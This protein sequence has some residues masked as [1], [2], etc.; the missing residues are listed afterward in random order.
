MNLSGGGCS[1]EQSHSLKPFPLSWLQIDKKFQNFFALINKKDPFSMENL[2]HY[3]LYRSIRDRKFNVTDKI[4]ELISLR[5]TLG[6]ILVHHQKYHHHHHDADE[7]LRPEVGSTPDAAMV[8]TVPSSWDI[9]LRPVWPI[10]SSV[11]LSRYFPVQDITP[12][13][14]FWNFAPCLWV[15]YCS[16]LSDLLTF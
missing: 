4:P 1:R 16:S 14:I 15:W 2:V 9:A 11:D 10:I 13:L 8:S 7:W 12:C 3:S 6:T 5:T